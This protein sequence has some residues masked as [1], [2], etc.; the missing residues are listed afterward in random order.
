MRTKRPKV[1]WAILA[2]AMISILIG[3]SVTVVATVAAEV[4][5]TNTCTN[6][7]NSSSSSRLVSVQQ[8]PENLDTCTLDD[9]AATDSSELSSLQQDK[10]YAELQQDP[11][12]AEGQASTSPQRGVN[13]TPTLGQKEERE[14]EELRA[15]GARTPVRTIRDTYPSY[16][17][18]AVRRQFRRSDFARQQFVGIPGIRP[19]V[20]DSCEG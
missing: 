13:F 5:G 4:G 17:S 6:C 10:L 19:V 15:H 9:S 7:G 20:A 12:P 8:I 3:L 2:S 1:D 14:A 18:V 11:T 16:S